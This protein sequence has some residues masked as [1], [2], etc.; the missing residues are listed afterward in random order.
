VDIPPNDIADPNGGQ[1]WVF[2]RTGADTAGELL[3]ADL[4]VSPGGFVREHAHPAQ[5]ETFTGISG[6]FVLE[7]AGETKR[8]GPGG[9]VVI[10]PGTPHGFKDAA[11]E[12]HLLVEVRPALHLDD[13]FRTFLG[14]SRDGRISMPAQGLPHPLLQVALVLERYAPEI[15]APRIPLGL[16]RLLWRLIGAFARRRGVPDSFPE[17]GA[18]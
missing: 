14:L 8:I 10:P 12:A 9:K 13:Y 6:T 18:P 17:Y 15:A 16:Q 1:R 11:E 7:V 4:F 2:R 3:E 5:E